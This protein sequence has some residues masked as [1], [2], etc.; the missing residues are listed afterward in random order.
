MLE[1]FLNDVN[2][3]KRSSSIILLLIPTINSMDPSCELDPPCDLSFKTVNCLLPVF[4]SYNQQ[5]VCYKITTVK[6]HVH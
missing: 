1:H 6:E 4:S 2:N 3:G 5:K